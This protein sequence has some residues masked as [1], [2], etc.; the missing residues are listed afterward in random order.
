MSWKHLIETIPSIEIFHGMIYILKWSGWE[1]SIKAE[2]LITV[3]AKKLWQFFSSLRKMI[4]LKDTGVKMW[5]TQM[6]RPSKE[7]CEAKSILWKC[8]N[9]NPNYSLTRASHESL[10]NK[11]LW[12]ESLKWYKRI[13]V[14][15]KLEREA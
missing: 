12:G 14:I 15:Q 7:L 4:Y 11:G 1:K 10:M 6:S 13:L 5:W 9:V 8:G 3:T 2:M